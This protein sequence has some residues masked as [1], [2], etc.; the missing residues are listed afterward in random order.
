MVGQERTARGMPGSAGRAIVPVGASGRALPS[1]PPAGGLEIP[2]PVPPEQETGSAPAHLTGE[3]RASR[4]TRRSLLPLLSNPE[5]RT[6]NVERPLPSHYRRLPS[7]APRRGNEMTAQGKV[8][9]RPPPW[10][11]HTPTPI[12]PFPVSR[13]DGGAKQEK[14]R[15][16]LPSR[17]PGRRF[18]VP[19]AIPSCPFRTHRRRK[20]SK[21]PIK[22]QPL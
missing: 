2:R 22:G 1:L 16:H 12:F 4:E 7:L 20:Q 8:A 6:L 13:R 18:A 17:H 3:S 9:S 10:V 21:S 14:G 11:N 19:W 15:V 5:F